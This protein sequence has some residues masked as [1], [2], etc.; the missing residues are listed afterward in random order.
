MTVQFKGIK[1]DEHSLALRKKLDEADELALRGIALLDDPEVPDDRKY[2]ILSQMNN[3]AD[4][5]IRAEQAV[6]EEGTR[7]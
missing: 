1:L 7:A 4:W 2:R 3:L 6:I 5:V